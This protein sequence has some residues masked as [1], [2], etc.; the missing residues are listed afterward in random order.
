MCLL[1]SP[2]L[3]EAGLLEDPAKSRE[4]NQMTL[5]RVLTLFFLKE[6][7][8]QAC[9]ALLRLWKRAGTPDPGTGARDAH[10]PQ[11]EMLGVRQADTQ[12]VQ[13]DP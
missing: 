3:Q 4:L 10:S 7:N 9:L 12:G 11:W 1:T 2:L 6:G 5:V 13:E 8:R